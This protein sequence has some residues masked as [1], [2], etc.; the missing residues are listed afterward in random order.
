MLL[1]P[2]KPHTMETTMLHRVKVALGRIFLP[3]IEAAQIQPHPTLPAAASAMPW[4][5]LEAWDA[6]A[7]PIPWQDI[8]AEMVGRPC[9]VGLD[10]SCRTRFVT[11]INL[12]P[13][14]GG[15][16]AWRV[17]CRC[18]MPS[19]FLRVRFETKHR[20]AYENWVACGAL[21]AEA[22]EAVTQE[23]IKSSVLKTAQASQSAEVVIDRWHQSRLVGHLWD[24]GLSVAS[25]G[26][27]FPSLSP[28]SRILE[29]LVQA[30]LI[31]HG[32]HPVL[33]WMVSNT[34]VT[35]DGNGAI[36]PIPAIDDAVIGGVVALVAALGQATN[37]HEG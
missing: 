25:F 18:W 15:D 21:L 12:Y 20:A 14:Q 11:Q 1:P 10:L 23:V 7:G 37:A 35:R 8:D 9:F 27:G 17:S 24:A 32:G 33:R 22:T 30:G 4:L 34:A 28:P 19:K 13:P 5:P 26:M 36:K 31:H 2:T 16:T 29:S 3:C 6:C